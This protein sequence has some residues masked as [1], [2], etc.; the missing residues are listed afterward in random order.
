MGIRKKAHL[1]IALLRSS[2][3]DFKTACETNELVKGKYKDYIASSIY[4]H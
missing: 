1:F 4:P 3:E 2:W